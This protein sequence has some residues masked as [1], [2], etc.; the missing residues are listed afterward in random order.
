MPGVTY[1]REVRVEHGEPLV[2]HS[3]VAPPPGGLYALKPVLSNDSVL[4]R[5]T[6]SAIQQRL[7]PQ[8]TVAGVNGDLFSFDD[9]HPTGILLRPPPA[10]RPNLELLAGCG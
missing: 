1:T 6:V 5:E 4:G 10:T 2:V 7:S 9:G 3:I 8:A